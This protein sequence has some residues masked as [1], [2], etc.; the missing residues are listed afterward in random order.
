MT[1]A[2]AYYHPEFIESRPNDRSVPPSLTASE[3]ASKSFEQLAQQRRPPV[4]LSVD[5]D[6]T[7]AVHKPMIPVTNLDDNLELHR[8]SKD[9][10]DR[11]SEARQPS[12]GNVL[13]R[14]MRKE[15][16]YSDK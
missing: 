5:V 1:Y 15:V 11:A 6:I 8:I 12:I 14:D 16:S 7:Q 2:V 9:L 3:T 4:N 13:H 10:S